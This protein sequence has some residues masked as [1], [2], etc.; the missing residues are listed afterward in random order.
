MQEMITFMS[1]FAWMCSPVPFSAYLSFWS[2]VLKGLFGSLWG[3]FAV[4]LLPMSRKICD[5]TAPHVN[6]QNVG[7][8]LS[9]RNEIGPNCLESRAFKK[10]R[11][12]TNFFFFF[13]AIV[14][15]IESS[16]TGNWCKERKGNDTYQEFN[17]LHEDSCFF[18]WAACST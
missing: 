8:G 1:F 12:T 9:S 2:A 15:F 4:A 11:W 3:S 7:V 17:Q 6:T 5:A 10:F 16:W 18:I 14:T 13:E